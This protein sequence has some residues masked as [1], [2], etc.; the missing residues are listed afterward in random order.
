MTQEANP[1]RLRCH[2]RC[3]RETGSG[4][5]GH[6]QQTL[7]FALT[8]RLESSELGIFGSPSATSQRRLAIEA[9]PENPQL[10]DFSPTCA[11]WIASQR[12]ERAARRAC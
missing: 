9:K 7:G 8:K 3:G 11:N 5:I 6:F 10:I 1:V 12:E 4:K 2:L